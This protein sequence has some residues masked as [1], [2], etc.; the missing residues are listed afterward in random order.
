MSYIG[1]VG[2]LRYHS[3]PSTLRK[4]YQAASNLAYYPKYYLRRGGSLKAGLTCIIRRDTLLIILKLGRIFPSCP[5][6]FSLGSGFPAL[7]RFRA[8]IFAQSR[9][10]KSLH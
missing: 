1:Y 6:A 4:A 3:L 7:G 5:Y 10:S 2:I 8:C 9:M